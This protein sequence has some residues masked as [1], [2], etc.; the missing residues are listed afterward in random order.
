MSFTRSSP[1]RLPSS[2]PDRSNLEETTSE[3][4]ERLALA[5]R[6]HDGPAQRLIALGFELDALIGEIDLAPHIR[7]RIRE[8]RFEVSA[9]SSSFRDEIYLLRQIS[10]AKLP[11]LIKSILP[12]LHREINLPLSVFRPEDEAKISS[13]I[14]EIARNTSRHSSATEFVI[15]YEL[16][17]SVEI[18]IFDNGQGQIT[19]KERSFGLKMITELITQAGGEI[20]W[21]SGPTGS[22]FR[23]CMPLP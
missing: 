6:L 2:L 7:S 15:S 23:I 5:R 19:L 9:I 3:E 1:Q 18:H 10:F 12:N 14:L 11:N 8:L 20:E 21:S 22:Q 4:S 17:S 13:A 16:T